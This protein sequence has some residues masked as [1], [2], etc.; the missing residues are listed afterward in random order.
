MLYFA[1]LV[2]RSRKT[3]GEKWKT[4]VFRNMFIS[5][6]MGLI[7][8]LNW[9]KGSEELQLVMRDFSIVEM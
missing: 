1:L 5:I 2:Q 8:Y 9:V 3:Q 6:K 7:G 4:S